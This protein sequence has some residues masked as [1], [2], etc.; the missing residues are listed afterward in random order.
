[1]KINIRKTH[2]FAEL[3]VDEIETTIFAKSKKEIKE[4]VANL[5]EV[6]E[7]LESYLGDIKQVYSEEEV[8]TLLQDLNNQID[9][10]SGGRAL[11]VSSLVRW[12]EENKK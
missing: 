10:T 5:R 3:K 8:F 12:F 2:A 7:D 1:M 11:G 6:A 9:F 4:T